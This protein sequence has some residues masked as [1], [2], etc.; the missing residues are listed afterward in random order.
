MFP[1]DKQM[2]IKH[3]ISIFLILLFAL[4]VNAEVHQIFKDG[5]KLTLELEEVSLPMVLNMIAK[6]YNLNLVL[7]S[8]VEGEVSIRLDQVD[9]QTALEAIL[10]PN[11]LNYYI[12]ENVII[13]KSNESES[14]GEFNSS[15]VT[16]K[17]ADVNMVL[18]ALIT[19]K[20]PKGNVIILDK[21]GQ[22]SSSDGTYT[23]NKLFISDYPSVVEG[24]LAAV[25]QLDKPERLIS[26]AVKIIETQVDH[27]LKVGLN[28]PT[29]LNVSLADAG[30]D[31]S[32]SST[33]TTSTSEETSGSLAKDLNSGNWVWGKLTVSELTTVLNL[34]EQN[35]NSKLISDPHVTTLENHEAD[36]T[37][38]TVIPIA[39]INRFTEAAST[40]DI[41]T[42]YDEEVGISL[43]VTPR[44]NENGLIT[45]MV[46]PKI[47]DI[48]GYTGPADSQK[49]ITISRSVKTR[50][51]VNDGETAALGGL[52]KENEI[53]NRQKVPVLGS[54]PLLGSLFTSKSTEKST[55]DLIILIT[56]TILK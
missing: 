21:S 16:L 29:Q 2:K 18:E 55:T 7:A 17:Y 28:W 5:E 13:V 11:E 49:P 14:F 36:I 37:I 51:T 41:V 24:M 32:A 26:I 12:K 9:I 1:R 3:T 35:G 15:V 53:E 43:K 44:I 4:N 46:E 56:P 30:I 25:E 50:I 8:N 38:A 52:L 54:I 31:P 23:P 33:S 47:E 6:Q 34:L 42:F 20:S 39:T 22:N 19:L 10:Y 45:L 48:I 40:Q 27:S